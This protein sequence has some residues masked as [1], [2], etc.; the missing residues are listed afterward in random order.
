MDWPTVNSIGCARIRPPIVPTIS[1]AEKRESG[2]PLDSSSV[3]ARTSELIPG[4]NSST[5]PRMRKLPEGV[6]TWYDSAT[7]ARGTLIR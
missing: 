3:I 4:L 7:S 1:A 6:S 2:V 5:L